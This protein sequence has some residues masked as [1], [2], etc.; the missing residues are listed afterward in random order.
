MEFIRSLLER[1]FQTAFAAVVT[2]MERGVLPDFLT[3]C[4]YRRL[5]SAFPTLM[6]MQLFLAPATR[7]GRVRRRGIRMLLAK[8]LVEVWNLGEIPRKLFSGT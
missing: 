4:P 8:R 5:P 6:R 7:D 3:R 2:L 1:V